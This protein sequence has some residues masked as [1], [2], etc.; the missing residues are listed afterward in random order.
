MNN[1]WLIIDNGWR[2]INDESNSL[3]PIELP[4]VGPANALLGLKGPSAAAKNWI[5][6]N[7][8]W[9]IDNEKFVVDNEYWKKCKT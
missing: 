9:I 8:K 1:G 5:F 2:M 4:L 7:E 3:K 6:S